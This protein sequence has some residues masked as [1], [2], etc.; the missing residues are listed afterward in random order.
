MLAA[1]QTVGQ[2]VQALEISEQTFHRWRR[3]YGG[4]TGSLEQVFLDTFHD[5]PPQRLLQNATSGQVC[6]AAQE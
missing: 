4:M 3:Q 1:G 5:C 2:V 6:S